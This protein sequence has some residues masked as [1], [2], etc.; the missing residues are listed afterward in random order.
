LD[1]TGWGVSSYVISTRRGFNQVVAEYADTHQYIEDIFHLT[2]DL[3]VREAE[4]APEDFSIFF[5]PA[6]A[7]DEEITRT[8]EV[9]CY[10]YNSQIWKRAAK[11]G[12]PVSLSGYINVITRVINR[13]PG[14]LLNDFKRAHCLKYLTIYQDQNHRL[15]LKQG[16]R[17]EEAMA[18]E[19]LTDQG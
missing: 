18:P 2:A 11:L 17:M 8:K 1:L 15:F 19:R 7:T 6:T 3:C 16:E 9:A 13:F 14:E 10:F 12:E 4:V 5:D